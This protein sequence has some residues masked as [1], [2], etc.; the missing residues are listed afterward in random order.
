[1]EDIN[2][3]FFKE[4]RHM[5]RF[6]NHLLLG[7]CKS[8]PQWDVTSHLSEWLKSKT[9]ETT[10]VGKD[11]EKK[12]LFCTFGGNANGCSHCRGHTEVPQKIKKKI[13]LWSSNHTT[14]YLP[15]HT[16][17]TKG[18]MHPYVYW[19]IIYNSQIMNAA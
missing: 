14:G 19:S 7:K 15:N 17:K 13:I 1:M 8:K 9:R 18:Y 5:K 6:S 11:V 10:S 12:E 16:T 4:G 2:W 3:Y